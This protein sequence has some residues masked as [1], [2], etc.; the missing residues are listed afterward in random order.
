MDRQHCSRRVRSAFT[1]TELVVVLVILAATAALVIPRLGFLKTQSDTATAG[2]GAAQVVSNLETY[3]LATGRYP[4]G[5][6]SLLDSADTTA[7]YSRLWSHTTGANT[8]GLRADL[9]AGTVGSPYAQ[10]FGHAFASSSGYYVYDHLASSTDP[11]NSATVLRTFTSASTAAVAT[12]TGSALIRA[13]GYPSG[14]LPADGSVK[15]IAFGVGP[16]TGSIGDTMAT[17]PRHAAQSQ[18][19]YGRYVAI[20]ALYANGKAAELKTVV[21]SFGSTVDSNVTRFLRSSPTHE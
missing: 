18:E 1:L 12:V 16:N 10:S 21:D 11:T 17:A 2:A 14:T 15:L 5:M 8:L 3:R 7:L 13:A 20:F 4:L 19:Y 6:D 9:T